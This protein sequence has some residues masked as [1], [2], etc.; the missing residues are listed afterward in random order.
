[1]SVCEG[2]GSNG[3]V[4]KAQLFPIDG[5]YRA[6]IISDVDNSR[7]NSIVPLVLCMIAMQYPGHWYCI[8]GALG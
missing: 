1:V 6:D 5:H 3:F 8:I 4:N 2:F 7:S